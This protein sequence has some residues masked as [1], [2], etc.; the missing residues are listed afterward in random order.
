MRKNTKRI[1]YFSVLLLSLMLCFTNCKLF[2]FDYKVYV[3]KTGG[4]YHT[5]SCTYIKKAKNVYWLYKSEAEA[6]GYNPCSVC[7]P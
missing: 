1:I 2:G 4:S 7:K 6:Q 3:T 5:H